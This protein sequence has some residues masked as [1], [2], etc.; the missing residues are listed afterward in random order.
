MGS[1]EISALLIL[2][3]SLDI[4]IESQLRAAQ[5]LWICIPVT[6]MFL[7]FLPKIVPLRLL[8]IKSGKEYSRGLPETNLEKEHISVAI[9]F[10]IYLKTMRI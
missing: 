4:L 2:N 7:R 5:N 8:K 6:V 9:E 1:S 10:Q 3:S